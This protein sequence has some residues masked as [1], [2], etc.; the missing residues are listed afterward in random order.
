[1]RVVLRYLA[2]GL[3]VWLGVSGILLGTYWLLSIV[4]NDTDAALPGFQHFAGLLL[5][6]VGAL[7]V[8]DAVRRELKVQLVR[9]MERLGNPLDSPTQA[10]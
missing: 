2:L 8:A 4:G 6:A 9:K 7:L 1:M 5:M 10:G 3:E